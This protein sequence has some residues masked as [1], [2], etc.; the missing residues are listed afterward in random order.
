MLTC[1]AVVLCLSVICQS[2]P[3]LDYRTEASNASDA[4]R[5]LSMRCRVVR[6]LAPINDDANIDAEWRK[7]LEVGRR[8]HEECNIDYDASKGH[9]R[10][11]VNDLRDVTT[12]MAENNIP[13]YQIVNVS[14]SFTM[15]VWES[16]RARWRPMPTLLVVE[17]HDRRPEHRDQ[18]V[19][20]V[21]LETGCI[22]D[23]CFDSS[24][25]SHEVID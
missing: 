6:T 8:Q 11:E 25:A 14:R 4:I 24:Q 10:I 18:P 23:A 15:L 1:T 5:T 3:S 16:G 19:F 12:L 21:P 2:A 22:P 20:E 7:H 13:T 17:P 9:W